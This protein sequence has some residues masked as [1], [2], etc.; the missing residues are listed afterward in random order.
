MQSYSIQSTQALISLVDSDFESNTTLKDKHL[1][2]IDTLIRRRADKKAMYLDSQ[3]LKKTFG[4][5]EYLLII[6][7]FI[8]KGI[9]QRYFNKQDGYFSYYTYKL[10]ISVKKLVPYQLKS[11]SLIRTIDYFHNTNYNNL[12]DFEKQVL[13]NIQKLQL[14]SEFDVPRLYMTKSKNTGRM[15]HSITNM[16]K[17]QRMQLKHVD[18]IRLGEFDAKN[19]QLVMLSHM[20]NDD[21]V[22]NDAV[23]GGEFYNIMADEMGV[24]ISNEA[25]KKE[26]KRKFFNSILFNEN[27]LV[28]AN[29]KYGKAFKNLFPIT[30]HHLIEMQTDT[31]KANELQSSESNLFIDNITRD[32]V[33][34]GLFV[35][36]IHDAIIFDLD[37][38]DSVQ[39]IID[40]NCYSVLGRLITLSLEE[41]C[42]TPCSQYTT[43]NNIYNK[44]KEE[45]EEEKDSQRGVYVVQN[46]KGVGQNKN[47][48]LQD[49]K[50]AAVTHAIKQIMADNQKITIRKIQELSGVAKATVEKHYKLILSQISQDNVAEE[51][52]DLTELKVA[53]S[54]PIEDKLTQ[55]RMWLE[56]R[57]NARVTDRM[58]IADLRNVLGDKTTNRIP[59][60]DRFD[61]IQG[62][63]YA[64]FD[65]FW[66]NLQNYKSNFV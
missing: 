56:E 5:K 60:S 23:Y 47:T 21:E 3:L 20:Y 65:K 55:K 33:N 38:I 66:S 51:Q 57:F 8:E 44:G 1:Y 12:R 27:I 2:F 32:L 10:L 4:D 14:P 24:D 64:S 22:F 39:K 46:P 7:Y 63:N 25:S 18:G 26:F 34:E 30:Y 53:D 42:P 50:V 13:H 52:T 49:E 9:V 58:L 19:A 16:P 41:F 54:A 6:N 36:P 62:I 37:K 11:P 48:Q 61:L 15:F 29:S 59:V 28:V 35:I 43:Y 17:N 31:S 45:G 40:D